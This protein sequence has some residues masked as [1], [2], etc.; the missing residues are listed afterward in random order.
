MAE[1]EKIEQ[2][3]KDRLK[4]VEDAE[5]AEAARLQAE[6]QAQQAQQQP[7][8]AEQ[9][10]EQQADPE[11]LKLAQQAEQDTAHVPADQQQE[12]Q[13]PLGNTETSV[14]PFTSLT[15][16]DSPGYNAADGSPLL[17]WILC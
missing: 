10:A 2:A 12:A 4:A 6:Q 14:Q 7:P 3:E 5:T 11:F 8:T 1:Q 13:A 17:L 15:T 9:L 16:A